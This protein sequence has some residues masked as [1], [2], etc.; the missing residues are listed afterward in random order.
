MKKPLEGF[1]KSIFVG[2]D[3]EALEKMLVQT[4]KVTLEG[5]EGDK[6]AGLTRL[7]DVRVPHYPPGTI[8]RNTR[9]VSIVSME[10]LEQIAEALKVPTI[11]AEWLGANLNLLGIPN[12]TQL[13]PSTRLFFPQDA[14]LVIDCENEPCT[15][16]GRAIQEHYP[17]VPRLTSAFPKAAI[18]KRGLV[19]WVERAGMI[20]TGDTV[21]VDLPPQVTYSY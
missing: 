13:P 11:S 10:E 21:G 3:S 12:L 8:I 5:F 7:S 15:G 18:H 9:Q 1:V 20:V 4:V 14:V 16:P 6:H 19:A 2:R 17:D